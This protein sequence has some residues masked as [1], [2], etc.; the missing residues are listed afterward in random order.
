ME[1]PITS[2]SGRDNPGRD[3]A[4]SVAIL[5]PMDLRD[6]TRRIR[7]AASPLVVAVAL[8]FLGPGA[9]EEE[10]GEPSGLEGFRADLPPVDAPD[11]LVEQVLAERGLLDLMS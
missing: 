8:G 11:S 6:S 2:G 5:L 3:P 10:E 7:L 4:A 9:L 1:P